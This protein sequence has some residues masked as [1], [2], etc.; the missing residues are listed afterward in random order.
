L[1]GRPAAQ[2]QDRDKNLQPHQSVSSPTACTGVRSK[3]AFPSP[4]DRHR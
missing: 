2:Q 1:S 4:T 3:I